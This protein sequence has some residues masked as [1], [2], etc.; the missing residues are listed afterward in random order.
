MFFSVRGPPILGFSAIG[1]KHCFLHASAAASE[2]DL[3]FA[4]PSGV[5]CGDP[6]NRVRRHLDAAVF[7]Q[8]A[9]CLNPPES[10][11]SPYGAYI[12]AKS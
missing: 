1:D 5:L 6:A 9:H 10:R 12:T 4:N 2:A 8:V 7:P 3:S 11:G